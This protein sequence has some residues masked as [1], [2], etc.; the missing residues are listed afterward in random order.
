MSDELH[1]ILAAVGAAVLVLAFTPA[2]IRV[3]RRTGFLDR[4][5]GYKQ[6]DAAT[7][8]LG[9]SAVLLAVVISSLIFSTRLHWI[10]PMLLLVVP[11]WIVG[12]IDDRRHVAWWARVALEIAAGVVLWAVGLG[13]QVTGGDAVDLLLTCAWVVL[14]VNA[15]NLM[16]NLDGAASSVAAACGVGIAILA[17]TE[18]RE[19]TAVL[20]AAI[21]GASL[22]FLVYNLAGPARIF[23]GDGGSM[24]IGFL[25]ATTSMRAAGSIG[26]DWWGV[27]AGILLVGVLLLDTTL[28]VVSRRRR[29][30]SVLTAGRDHFSHRLLARLRT[31]RVVAATLAAFQ[32]VLSLAAALA[33]HARGAVLAAVVVTGIV[34]GLVTI[35]ALEGAHWR[36]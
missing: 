9:G 34:I 1:A 33:A 25:L 10:G 5:Q 18:D 31:P 24:P 28:V 26:L 14:V 21:T 12:T 16:D 13:W 30:V 8:Y 3:A 19:N 4:P 22:A 2:A 27:L 17:L 23:L 20:A 32:I 35:R 6:H 11:L 29:G 36:A 7:P 15:C